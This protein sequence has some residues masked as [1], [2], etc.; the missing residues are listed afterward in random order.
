MSGD[1]PASAEDLIGLLDEVVWPHDGH[2][3]DGR[4]L[5]P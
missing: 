4:L 2:G 3:D 5:E 1:F